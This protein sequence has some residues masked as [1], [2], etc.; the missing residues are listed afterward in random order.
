MRIRAIHKITQ[1]A[2]ASLIGQMGQE[3]FDG[4]VKES[5]ASELAKLIIEKT[6]VPLTRKEVPERFPK[7]LE[8]QKDLEMEPCFEYECQ[9]ILLNREDFEIIMDSIGIIKARL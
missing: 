4:F 9:F 5:L 3:K 7:G 8:S 2:E 6:H 1:I